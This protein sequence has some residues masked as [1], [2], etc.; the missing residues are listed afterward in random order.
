MNVFYQ[1]E[2]Y[3][4]TIKI[5]NRLPSSLKDLTYKKKQFKLTLK[6]YLLENSFYSLQEFFNTK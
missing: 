2:V 3:Y 5:Y 1:K 4:M 6:R